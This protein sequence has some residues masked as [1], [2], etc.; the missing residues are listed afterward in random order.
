MAAPPKPKNED[1]ICLMCKKPK[2]KHTVKEIQ[3][4]YSKLEEFRGQKAGG[5]GIQ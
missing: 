4:C 2:S 3:V 1:E 5:A